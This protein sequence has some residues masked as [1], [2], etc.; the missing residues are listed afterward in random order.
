MNGSYHNMHTYQSF[1]KPYNNNQSR[2]RFNSNSA[3]ITPKEAREKKLQK[4]AFK[5]I[6]QFYRQQI[7]NPDSAISSII[8]AATQKAQSMGISN[9]TFSKKKIYQYCNNNGYVVKE[10]IV[11]AYLESIQNEPSNF[12]NVLKQAYESGLNKK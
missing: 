3:F 6:N 4:Q 10:N 1:N 11:N 7:Q 8:T 9:Q 5:A 2:L 12:E